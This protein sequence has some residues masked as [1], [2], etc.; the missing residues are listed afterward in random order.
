MR[1][2]AAIAAGALVLCTVSP[3]RAQSC[4]GWRQVL[5]P[6]DLPAPRE[7]ACLVFDSMR[8]EL[9]LYGGFGGV[10]PQSAYQGDTWT[11]DG[12]TWTRRATGGPLPRYGHAM[13]FDSARGVVLM[14]GGWANMPRADLW[15]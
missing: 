7:S 1:W 10:P 11:W 14:H 12:T 4:Y 2:R 3:T 6:G 5:P 9:V 13:A 8:H 15:Q